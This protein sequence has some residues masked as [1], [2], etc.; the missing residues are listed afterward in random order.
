M[1]ILIVDD[2][3]DLRGLIAYALRQAG[4]LA[5]EAADGAAALAAYEREEP[6]LV[7]LDVNLP[8]L[9]GFPTSTGSK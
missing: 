8:R 9:S 3:A 5:I 2:D 6:A 1:K 7:I 4:Y